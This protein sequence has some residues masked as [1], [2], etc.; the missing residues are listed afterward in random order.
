VKDWLYSFSSDIESESEEKGSLKKL[1]HFV[2]I[3]KGKDIISESLLHETLLFIDTKFI[4]SLPLLSMR[5]YK[6]VYN[7]CTKNNCFTESDNSSL[8]R[9]QSGPKA[10]HKLHTACDATI[11]HTKKRMKS[12]T[13]H[14]YRAIKQS[15]VGDVAIP[16]LKYVSK[17]IVEKV[18]VKLCHQ[19]SMRDEFKHMEG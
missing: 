17:N 3:K 2:V 9:D 7:A 18:A 14:A 5:Q 19:W 15:M 6:S 10:N 8:K 13:Q 11:L 12:L 16:Q 4:P 1:K